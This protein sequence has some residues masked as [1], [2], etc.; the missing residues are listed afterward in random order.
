[1]T[2]RRS[3]IRSK[4]G[5]RA[6]GTDVKQEKRRMATIL[7]R[8]HKEYPASKCSLLFDKP[9]QLVLATILSAQCTDERVNMVTPHLFARYP[10]AQDLAD[11]ELAEVEDIVRSTGFFRNKAR[12]LVG[13]AQHLVMHHDGE[14]PSTLE[15]LVALP[16]VG[17]KTANVVLGNAF[18]IPGLVVDTHVTRISNLLELTDNKDA[19]K[20]E[21]DL[22]AVT[23]R[24]EWSNVAHL[25]IDHGRKVCIAR[26]PQCDVCVLNYLCPSSLV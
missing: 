2:A 26:R 5:R 18:G 12:N 4:A 7:R 20:I 10:T 11:A 14:V 23:P 25:F 22:M 15:E 19:V 1:M 21:H 24:K 13:C 8:L 3:V 9:L 17:R 16:G 6:P